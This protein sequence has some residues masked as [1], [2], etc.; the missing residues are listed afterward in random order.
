LRRKRKEKQNEYIFTRGKNESEKVKGTF[1]TR[2]ENRRIRKKWKVHEEKMNGTFCT[3][4]LEECRSYRAG[5]TESFLAALYLACWLLAR[6]RKIIE[7]TC[8]VGGRYRWKKRRGGRIL[9]APIRRRR[10]RDR[11]EEGGGKNKYP[12]VSQSVEAPKL[13]GI[14][15]GTSCF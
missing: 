11:E 8:G 7:G 2:E 5:T 13:V 1:C 10:R 14:S 6:R 9:L 3:H 15:Q 4:G 12:M